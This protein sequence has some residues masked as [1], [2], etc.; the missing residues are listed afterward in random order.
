[1]IHVSFACNNPDTGIFSG[2]FS[3]IEFQDVHGET[4]V[5]LTGPETAITRVKIRG[6]SAPV[7]IVVLGED[8]GRGVIFSGWKSYEGNWCWEACDLLLSDA[9]WL[10]PYLLEHDFQVD[11]V[12]LEDNPLIDLLPGENPNA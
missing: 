6:L 10:L 3:A 11:E 8:G 1:M 2:E 5:S 7:E 12:A 4:L 9:R